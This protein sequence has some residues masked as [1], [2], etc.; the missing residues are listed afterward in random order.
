MIIRYDNE[1]EDEFLD[2]L[3]AAITDLHYGYLAIG[4]LT[5]VGRGLFSIETINNIELSKENPYNQ[6]REI[7]R[8]GRDGK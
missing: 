2:I 6:I 4:G 8:K 5:S 1:V 3:A 7:L